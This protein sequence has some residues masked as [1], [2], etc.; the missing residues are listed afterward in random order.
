MKSTG[1]DQ[2]E[3][4]PVSHVR[5]C[6]SKGT[7][8]SELTPS[9]RAAPLLRPSPETQRTLGILNKQGLVP[10]PTQHLSPRDTLE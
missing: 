6:D 4:G 5:S 8:P 9:P 7:V 3:E 1:G 10:T 2:P